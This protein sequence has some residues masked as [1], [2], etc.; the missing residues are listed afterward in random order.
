MDNY[1]TKFPQ[2]KHMFIHVPVLLINAQSTDAIKYRIPRKTTQI[3]AVS[4]YF[5]SYS[6]IWA[7]KLHFICF[8]RSQVLILSRDI[9]SDT[10][11]R[12]G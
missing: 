3:A 11:N 4:K 6:L 8:A 5:R 1:Q 7:Y 10:Y 2:Q 12:M 9:E